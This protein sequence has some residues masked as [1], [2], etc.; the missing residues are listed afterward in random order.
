MSRVIHVLVSG[1]RGLKQNVTKCDMEAIFGETF[2]E[3]QSIVNGSG[4]II[5]ISLKKKKMHK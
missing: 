4:V 3:K 1:L 2:G 5:T